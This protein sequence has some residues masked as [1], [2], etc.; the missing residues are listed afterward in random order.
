MQIA[1]IL[2]QSYRDWLFLNGFISTDNRKQIRHKEFI[3]LTRV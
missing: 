1:N 2:N 3:N